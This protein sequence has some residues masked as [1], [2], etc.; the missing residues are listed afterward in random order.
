M[1][2]KSRWRI[3]SLDNC[4]EFMLIDPRTNCPVDG[5]RYDMTAEEVIE[6][7]RDAGAGAAGTLFDA[8]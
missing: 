7:C 5:Y 6:Y 4:G 8:G 1:A 2:R 3:G